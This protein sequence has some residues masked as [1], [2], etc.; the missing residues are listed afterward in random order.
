[1]GW[2]SMGRIFFAIFLAAWAAAAGADELGMT[3]S[4]RVDNLSEGV[5]TFKLD[6]GNACIAQPRTSCTWDIAYGS[7]TLDAVTGGK[8]YTRDFELSDESDIL[9]HCSFDGGKFSGDTC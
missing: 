6:G 4:V 7:H 1:M 2:G 8:H 3:Y 5:V 9:V